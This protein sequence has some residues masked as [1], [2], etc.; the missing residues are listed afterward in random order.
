MR[1]VAYPARVL[2]PHLD[3][4]ELNAT[5]LHAKVGSHLCYGD[6]HQGPLETT[7][8]HGYL[9]L[10]SLPALLPQLVNMASARSA[11]NYELNGLSFPAP[12]PTGSSVRANAASSSLEA[13]TLEATTGDHQAMLA[14]TI[15]TDSAEKPRCVVDAVFR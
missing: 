13:V 15:E 2:P 12:V 5:E 8:A 11:L 7:V 4:T 3:I 14:R 6:W 10:A 9:A 1:R